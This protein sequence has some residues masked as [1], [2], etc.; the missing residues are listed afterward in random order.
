MGTL[1]GC[2]ADPSGH[3]LGLPPAGDVEWLQAQPDL[4]D[5]ANSDPSMMPTAQILLWEAPLGSIHDDRHPRPALSWGLVLVGTPSLY[6]QTICKQ[7]LAQGLC[8]RLA[9]Q[10]RDLA[11]DPQNLPKGLSQNVALPLATTKTDTAG[12]QTP[13]CPPTGKERLGN[14]SPIFLS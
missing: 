12:S 4:P 13:M 10:D 1:Q 5:T 6:N 3:Q 8:S 2:P 9:T 14:K 11:R 7:K